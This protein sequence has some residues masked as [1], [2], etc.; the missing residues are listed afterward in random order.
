MIIAMKL[1]YFFVAIIFSLMCSLPSFSEV[2]LGL[3]LEAVPLIDDKGI[4]AALTFKYSEYPFVLSVRR[5]FSNDRFLNGIG[6]DYWYCNPKLVKRL[7][8]YFGP[9]LLFYEAEKKSFDFE[10]LYAG[11]RLVLGFNAFVFEQIE[12]CT[13]LSAEAGLTFAG[14]ESPS[15]SFRATCS[16]GC[17]YW[18]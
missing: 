13:Q 12:L 2:G 5:G 9:G 4:Q 16:A 1:K 3:Q 14:E 18:F 15:F 17:R 8:Y 10:Y 7:H 6:L 11:S